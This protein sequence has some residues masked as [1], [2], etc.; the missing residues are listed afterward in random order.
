MTSRIDG[1]SVQQH[2]QA[3]D[4]DAGAAGR[5]QAVFK[6]AD[7]IGVVVHRLMVVR[8]PFA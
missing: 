8:L 3:V 7:V 4:T 6:R 5:G 2:H 1:L